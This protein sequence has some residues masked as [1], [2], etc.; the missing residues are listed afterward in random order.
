MKINLP[1]IIIPVTA[2]L[3]AVGGSFASRASEKSS[4]VKIQGYFYPL[5]SPDCIPGILC[6]TSGAI[7]CTVVYRGQVYQEFGKIFPSDVPCPIVLYRN[8]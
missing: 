5:G 8:L 6:N 7:L 4:L 2:I 1:K 3:L